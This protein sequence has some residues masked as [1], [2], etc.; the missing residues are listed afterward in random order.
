[1]QIK[2]RRHDPHWR[3]SRSKIGQRH[4]QAIRRRSWHIDMGHNSPVNVDMLIRDLSQ[5]HIWTIEI[6]LGRGHLC[7]AGNRGCQVAEVRK[8]RRRI[9]R[10]TS[11]HEEHQLPGSM[12]LDQL[13]WK[14]D[15]TN[16][17]QATL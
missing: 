13:R 15:L 1:M 6:A 5:K 10:R 8:T 14:I 4:V 11:T 9:P 12:S 7:F 3:A 16:P 17:H 2:V